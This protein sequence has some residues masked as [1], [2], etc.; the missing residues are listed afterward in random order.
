MSVEA[1]ASNYKA[2][3]V[4]AIP[5]LILADRE[6]IVRLHHAGRIAEA[7]LEAAIVSLLPK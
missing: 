4:S 7:E 6:G 1:A 3:G 2:F 5:V